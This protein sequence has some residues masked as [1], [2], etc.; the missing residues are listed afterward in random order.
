VVR[1]A[2]RAPATPVP[3][4]AAFSEVVDDILTN[5]PFGCT[6]YESCGA[7]MPATEKTRE[8]FTARF[9]YEDGA[10]VAIATTAVT[11]SGYEADA[12]PALA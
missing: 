11:A 6:A 4:L 5:N 12:V 1:S 7:S 8:A 9:V 3:T 10:A 2:V